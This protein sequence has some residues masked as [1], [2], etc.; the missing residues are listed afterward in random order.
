MVD[1]IDTTYRYMT[2]SSLLHIS[3]PKQG[4]NDSAI[5]EWG[6]HC[7]DTTARHARDRCQLPQ[8][9]YVHPTDIHF[10]DTIA[11]HSSAHFVQHKYTSIHPMDNWPIVK[12]V[13]MECCHVWPPSD[14]ASIDGQCFHLFHPNK[15]LRDSPSKH[16]NKAFVFGKTFNVNALKASVHASNEAVLLFSNKG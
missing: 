3:H 16:Y 9:T 8:Y 14:R 10:L 6:N 7:H 15:I 11:I 13:M 2:H 12:T 1:N 4:T 5:P